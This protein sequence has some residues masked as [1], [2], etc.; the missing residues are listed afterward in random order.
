MPLTRKRI[1]YLPHLLL[2]TL[3]LYAQIS[4]GQDNKETAAQM[5]EIG[6][7]IFSQT[8]AVMEA[9]DIFI[10][11]VNMDPDNIRANYMAGLTTLY[12][13][14]KGE[15]TGY[16]L[17]VLE[18]DPEYSFDILFK[19]GQAYHYDYKFDDAINYYSRYKQKLAANGKVPAQEFASEKEVE[20]KQYECEQGSIMVEFPE[21]VK[22]TNV[23]AK[24]NSDMADYAP[25]VDQDESI[26]IFT[27]RRR[28]G[29]LNPNVASDNYPFEDIFIST[30]NGSGWSEA[31][32]IKQPINTLYHD[33]NVGLSKDAN[34]LFIYK[35]DNGGDIFTAERDMN[36]RWSEPKPIGKP[37]N[38]EYSETTVSL[39]PNGKTLFFA[40]DRKGGYGG[41]DLWLTHK[42]K[43][44]EWDNPKNLG[45]EI[46]T[47]YNEDGP[48]IG[49]DGKTLY[50]SSGGGEGMGGYDI[51]RVIY[52][53]LVSSWGAPENMGYPINTPDH[54]IYFAPTKDG[55]NAY[56][57]S[58][59][60]EGFGNSDIYMLKVPEVL[61]HEKAS[62]PQIKVTIVVHVF[63]DIN[64]LI[65]ATLQL[66]I[67]DGSGT[68]YAER[69]E[70]GVYNFASLNS[71][72]MQYQLLVDNY[73]F[74]PQQMNIEVP[75]VGEESS[76]IER[77]IN[78]VRIIPPPPPRAET[79]S[80]N[81]NKLRNIYFDFNVSKLKPEFQDKITKAVD[82]LKSNP[83]E[84]LVLAG[85]SDLIGAEKYNSGLSK[86]RA[87]AVK[88]ALVAKGI[89]SS[90]IQTRGEGSKYPLASNDNEEE[91]R[92]LNRRVEFKI[93]H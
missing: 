18:L 2:I 80:V 30:K 53:S 39:S 87:E 58:V 12:S 20:R 81:G 14:N 17:R 25:V 7:E 92:E 71:K 64:T 57:S 10:S 11:A 31:T 35:D 55:K 23:G 22:I 38:T 43:K 52:D 61:Q 34:T 3:C 75:G 74:E 76:I 36:G 86:R 60:D 29:N 33:S 37:I 8:L 88:K 82:R 28:N 50:F 48:F 62:K 19:I 56:Y 42:N 27:S 47:A 65:D 9:R 66:N 24:I 26:L 73:L 68:L 41:L 15:A 40:S 63:D 67:A 77:S 59:R 93:L 79:S 1:L 51:Y 44:G 16:F 4:L 83:S 32:N 72:T 70:P 21:N 90:R 54:D 84:R 6:D 69:K 91:G 46:N 45:E 13:I 89:A 5:V 78:L 49:Y 85:H